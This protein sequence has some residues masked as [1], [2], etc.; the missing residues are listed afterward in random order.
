[1][2]VR[3][4]SATNTDLPAAIAAGRFREDLYYRLNVIELSVPPL[5]ERKEDILPLARHF[6][7]DGQKLGVAGTARAAG[8]FLAGQRARADEHDPARIAAVDWQRRSRLPISGSAAVTLTSEPTHEREP[9]RA[10]IESA[11]SRARGVIARAAREL[12]LSRQAL[13]RRMEKLGLKE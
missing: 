5:A 6:L 12:G 4:I 8:A 11:L 3:V 13:Y 9:D 1:M 10:E 7:A 2:K